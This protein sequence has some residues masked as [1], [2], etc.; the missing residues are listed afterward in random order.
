[1]LRPA[2]RDEIRAY[3]EIPGDNTMTG[4][5]NSAINE[6]FQ[7]IT[8]QSKFPELLVLGTI[9]TPL[10][11]GVVELPAAL[12]HLDENAIYFLAGGIDD[13]QNRTQLRQFAR[14]NS[15]DVGAPYQWRLYGGPS[16]AVATTYVKKLAI[17]PYADIIIAT[18]RI[19]LN[20]YTSL[21]WDSDTT[22]PP[23][24]SLMETIILRVAARV[25]K[26]ANSR[27]AAKLMQQAAIAYNSLRASAL[28]R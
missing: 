13:L 25:A 5:I 28:A 27:L 21:T 15:T 6:V 4:L 26:Q 23:I 2:A 8:A 18:D 14:F 22:Q 11:N 24:A 3:A 20:Y 17:T 1:M 12:Q 10:A 16:A 19:K 9:L 7:S